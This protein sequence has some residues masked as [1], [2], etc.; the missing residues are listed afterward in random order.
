M[1]ELMTGE[2]TK[3]KESMGKIK[4]QIGSRI[5]SD[6]GPKGEKMNTLH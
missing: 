6:N 3:K 5:P 2:G 1:K 4:S